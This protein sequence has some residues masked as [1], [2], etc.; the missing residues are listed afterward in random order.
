[1]DLFEVYQTFK[2]EKDCHE[3][4]IKLRWDGTIKCAYCTSDQVYRRS[5]GNGLKCRS[6]NKSFTV[7]TGTIFHASK[8]SL[9]KWFLAI[10][11]ILAAKKG[12]SSLQLAR[13]IHVNKNTAWYM[14]LRLRKAMKSD[15]LLR[16]IVE[17]DE[18]FVGGALGNMSKE[19]KKERNPYRS[20]MTHKRAVLGIIER[21]TGKIS[22]DVLDHANG[23]NIKPIVKKKVTPESEIVTDGFGGYSGLDKH[24]QKHVKMNH[25]KGKRKEGI[26]NLNSIEGF[27][28]TIKRAVIGQYHKISAKHMQSYM[29]EISFKK[30]NEYKES[31]NLLL[32][33]V[34]A[35]R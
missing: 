18:T 19:K 17:I 25:E 11:Q 10:A 30:N 23:E 29:D 28:T 7:T 22:L 13:T 20:G 33:K 26:Y 14:Q 5:Y 34:C 31:F 12:I 21:T 16:G 32:I 3:Y 9:N 2:T 15:I 24:F 8:L 6:C 35:F 4:L 1:M 27:F